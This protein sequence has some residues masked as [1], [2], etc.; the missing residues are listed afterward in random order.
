M[1]KTR[2]LSGLLFSS[3]RAVRDFH[4]LVSAAFEQGRSAEDKIKS[5]VNK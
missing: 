2:G 1:S 5:E 4:L 3:G